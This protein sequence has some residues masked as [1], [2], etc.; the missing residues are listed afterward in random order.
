MR[1]ISYIALLALAPLFSFSQYEAV[2]FNY[3]RGIFNNGKP[4]PAETYF[5][6]QGQIPQSIG[7]VEVD[8]YS[9]KGYPEKDPLYSNLWKRP[10][11]NPG[12]QFVVPINFALRG[13]EE[14]DLVVSYYTKATAA[15]TE[16][17]KQEVYRV[18]DAYI[19]Q[20]LE[21]EEDEINLI[22]DDSRMVKDMNEIVRT[23]M[24]YY[25]NRLQLE[26][27]GFSDLVEEQ[28]DMIEESEQGRFLGRKA[29]EEEN[30]E[31]KRE[32]IVQLKT[33]LH[34]E[35]AYLFN[36]GVYRLED[37]KLIDDYQTADVKNI[38][39]LH[40]GYGGVYLQETGDGYDVYGH[41][42][43]AGL[44]LPLG[45]KQFSS[46]FWS[47]TAIMAGVF[48]QNFEVDDQAVATGPF[49]GRPYYLGVGYKFYR[50]LRLSAGAT[51]LEDMARDGVSANID[52]QIYVSPFISL[53]A[54]INLWIGLAK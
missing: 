11:K 24:K 47:N 8:I 49:V 44:T 45:K 6:I 27:R 12:N 42:A 38:F 22:K 39:A 15:Q 13:S 52:N 51:L 33:L 9:E 50:F 25:R 34:N 32:L 5:E 28:I 4:L 40:G 14:Y 7:M 36:M 21:Y 10:F 31:Q 48:F 2:Q 30:M 29:S 19:D 20:N 46:T 23:A 53:S 35:V 54:D 37:R 1:T 41:S 3:E 17:Y 16:E 26:F 18:L 43:M